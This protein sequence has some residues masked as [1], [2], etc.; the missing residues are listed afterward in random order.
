MTRTLRTVLAFI[1]A[2]SLPGLFFATIHIVGYPPMAVMPRWEA[3]LRT[4]MVVS[5]ISYGMTYT[6]GL[7]T[8]FILRKTHRESAWAYALAGAILGFLTGTTAGEETAT[9]LRIGSSFAV[10]GFCVALTFALIRGTGK[11]K[12]LPP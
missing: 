10:I 12:L 5:I 8:F 7:L 6:G 4:F 11:A 1:V 9:R 3:F 2:P